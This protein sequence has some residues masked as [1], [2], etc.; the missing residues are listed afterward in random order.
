MP[1]VRYTIE[2]ELITEGDTVGEA[3]EKA[4]DFFDMA[5]KEEGDE[6]VFLRI[7][8]TPGVALTYIPANVKGPQI[9]VDPNGRFVN[10]RSEPDADGKTHPIVLGQ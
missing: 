9:E 4:R 10:Q 7:R 5:A 1:T 8:K 3:M 6:R 2:M